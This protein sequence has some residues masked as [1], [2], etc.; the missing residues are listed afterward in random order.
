MENGTATVELNGGGWLKFGPEGFVMKRGAG[1]GRSINFR[2]IDFKIERTPLDAGGEDVL[3]VAH[4]DNG[5]WLKVRD[6]QIFLKRTAGSGKP[7]SIGLVFD[8]AGFVTSIEGALAA[9]PPAPPAL[10]KRKPGRPRKVQPVLTV[11]GN[12]QIAQALAPTTSAE[13]APVITSAPAEAVAL[14]ELQ[15]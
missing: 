9:L 12:A 8:F 15:S 1:P 7:M 2:L 13:T 10:P 6:S 11:D 14:G 4:L 3:A 5:C